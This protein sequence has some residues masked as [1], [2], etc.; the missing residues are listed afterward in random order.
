[1]AFN[2]NVETY[3]SPKKGGAGILFSTTS[4]KL[5]A[6]ALLQQTKNPQLKSCGFA[7][8]ENEGF[9]PPEV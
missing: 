6:H 2:I 1:M 3:T 5:I 8:A 4:S 7:I 9:E